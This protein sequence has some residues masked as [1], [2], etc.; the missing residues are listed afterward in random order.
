[1]PS[2]FTL[3]SLKKV[4]VFFSLKVQK[5]S[6]KHPFDSGIHSVSNIFNHYF[7]LLYYYKSM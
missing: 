3:S 6:A 5:N 7:N 2:L 4:D 1:M